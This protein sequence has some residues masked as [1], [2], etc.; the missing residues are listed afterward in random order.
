MG[1]RVGCGQA[2]S[3]GSRH[4]RL[5]G[6]SEEQTDG[7]AGLGRGARTWDSL[8]TEAAGTGVLIRRR[9]R[10]PCKALHTPSW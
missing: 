10:W 2:G 1:F 3:V 8:A 6:I 7:S 4:I 9:N 5:L